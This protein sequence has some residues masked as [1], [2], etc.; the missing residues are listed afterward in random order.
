MVRLTAPTLLWRGGALREVLP[1]SDV[2]LFVKLGGCH[3]GFWG[4]LPADP[5]IAPQSG[6]GDILGGWGEGCP[7]PGLAL[8]PTSHF[9]LSSP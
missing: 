4:S 3:S 6:P 5:R 2:F 7:S 8:V 1:L 9:F